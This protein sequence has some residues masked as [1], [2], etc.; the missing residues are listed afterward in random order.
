MTTNFS[1]VTGG[2]VTDLDSVTA[3]D[4]K[5]DTSTAWN[6]GFGLVIVHNAS[7][8]VAYLVTE[9]DATTGGR[10]IPASSTA[11]FGPY[12]RGLDLWLYGSGSG[13]AHYDFD[14]VASE[15]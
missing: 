3:A 5:L 7:D 8:A 14:L 13:S 6:K 12:P 2:S 10:G 9:D 15:G 4:R 1:P 11:V